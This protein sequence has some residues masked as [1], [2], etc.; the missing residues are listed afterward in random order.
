MRPATLFLC[1]F[2]VSGFAAN[3]QFSLTPQMGIEDPTTKISYNNGT[4]FVPLQSQLAPRLAL[5]LDYKFKQGHG[6]FIGLATS[7]S[8]LE[9]SFTSPESGM[10]QYSAMVGQMQA[11][12]EGGYQFTTKP[13]YFNKKSASN[14]SSSTSKMSSTATTHS[15]CG[16]YSYMHHCC[17]R[18]KLAQQPKQNQSWFVRIQPSLGMAFVPAGKSAVETETKA[19][20]PTYT[21]QAGAYSTAL[22]TGAGFEFGAAKRRFFIININYFKALSDQSAT[23]VTQVGG[24]NV[25]TNLNSK[26]GGWNASLGIPISLNKT[27]VAKPRPEVQQH[28]TCGDYYRSK[29]H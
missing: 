29:C 19:G 3:A 1:L 17:N 6:V 13:I 8:G 5:K 4:Y 20:Q 14:A 23:L 10:T 28:H 18:N 9:Y 25:V 12:F 22:V 15:D 26:V 16:G 21:Y 11:R 27:Q 2:V 7:R 24:K